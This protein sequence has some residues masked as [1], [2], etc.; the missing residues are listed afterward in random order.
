MRGDR[1]R[2]YVQRH[3]LV[4]VDLVERQYWTRPGWANHLRWLD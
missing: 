2:L 1:K 3:E 4:V